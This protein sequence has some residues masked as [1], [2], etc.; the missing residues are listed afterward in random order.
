[1]KPHSARDAR[2]ALAIVS[3]QSKST[4]ENGDELSRDAEE[5]AMEKERALVTWIRQHA[6]ILVGY[7][8]GVDS[9]YLAA[10]AL[11]AVGA[12]Q[13]LAVIGRSP[14]Y[15]DA[16]WATARQVARKFG[17]PLLE[18]DTNEMHDPRYTA[19]PTN[20]CYFCKSVLW[21]SLIPIAAARGFATVVDGTN[22]DDLADHRPG[23]AA[24]G[25][26][27]VAS[28]LAIVG[29]SKDEIRFLSRRRALPTW[30]Q[31]SS[32]C[33]SSRLPYGTEVTAERLYAVERAE[34][35]LRALGITGD[36][37]VRYHGDLARVELS[38]VELQRWLEPA[39]A[40]RISSAV[41]GAGFARVAI[42]LRGFRSGSLNI[43][44]GVTNA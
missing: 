18:I 35:A 19:N 44:S 4:S 38:A 6:P 12:E 10:V 3:E 14:S 43:L 1:M 37:R 34:A 2:A 41:R 31:P 22:A 7:S 5:R 8:G 42:D 32:P 40:S 20:R 26:R 23:K 16:Q 30:S 24:A 13:T 27:H 15:P 25:E 9:A 36:L 28:P 39:Y 21:D 17:I 29:L 33:L 11:D